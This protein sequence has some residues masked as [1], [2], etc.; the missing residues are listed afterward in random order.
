MSYRE[1]SVNASKAKWAS[2]K[3]KTPKNKRRKKKTYRSHKRKSKKC[4]TCPRFHKKAH[5]RHHKVRGKK[6]RGNCGLCGN[7]GHARAGVQD[8]FQQSSIPLARNH[9]F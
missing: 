1:H 9:D 2:K 6:V 8:H 5:H 4:G 7:R 3:R